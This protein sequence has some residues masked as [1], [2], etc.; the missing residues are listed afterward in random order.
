MRILAFNY[1]YPPLG[2]G[3]G[4][5]FQA[6]CE[7]WKKNHDIVV[8]TSHYRGLDRVER[9]GRLEIHRVPVMMRKSLPTATMPSLLSYVPASIRYGERLLRERKFDLIHSQFVVPS[10]PGAQRLAKKHG[11]PH[12]LTILGG[13]VYDPS[14][15]T[16]P[17]RVPLVRN[18]V[19]SLLNAADRV[20][21]GSNDVAESARRY[22]GVTRDIDVISLAITEP[23]PAPRDRSRF[24]LAEDDFVLVTVGR[25]VARKGLDELLTVLQQVDDPRQHLLVVGDG[26][27]KE[28]LGARAAELGLVE[29]V[30]LLGRVSEEDKW[31]AL[32]SADAYVSTSMHEGFGLV[33]LEGMHAGLPVVAYDHGG[34]TDFLTD[35][36]TGAVVP[37]NDTAR[38]GDAIRRL[39]EDDDFRRGCAGHNR[40]LVRDYYADRCAERYI[41]AFESTL[42]AARP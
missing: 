29:R 30:H 20:L 16:S 39:R 28:S 1:E 3:G 32:G 24:G 23:P 34:Q 33:F 22:Y 21:A 42:A 37:L 17:H 8:V 26:P 5:V 2:G 7:E 19:R 41:A 36:V 13:D 35:G 11:L 38:F 10:A 12:V 40:E 4:V 18:T 25:L 15:S 31:L 6:L 14:K 9:D 27:L